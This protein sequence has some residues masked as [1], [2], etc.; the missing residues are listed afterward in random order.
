MAN[1][2]G[3]AV[4]LE[5]WYSTCITYRDLILVLQPFHLLQEVI[6]YPRCDLVTV[7]QSL[8]TPYPPVESCHRDP[9]ESVICILVRC[10]MVLTAAEGG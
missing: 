9:K 4:I 8:T 3:V 10:R 2:L 7:H 1:P 6:A 5:A